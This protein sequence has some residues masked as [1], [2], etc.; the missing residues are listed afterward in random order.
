M[1]TGALVFLMPELNVSRLSGLTYNYH[2]RQV[3][4]VLIAMTVHTKY[5]YKHSH[6]LTIA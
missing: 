5:R 2:N 6:A 1:F 3:Q 4:S